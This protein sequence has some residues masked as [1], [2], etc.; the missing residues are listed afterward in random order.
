MTGKPKHEIILSAGM[1]RAGSAWFFNLTLDIWLAAGR[2]NIREY[3]ESYPLKTVLTE[4]NHNIDNFTLRKTALLMLPYLAGKSFT[5]KIHF[6]PYPLGKW[7]IRADV[8]RPTFIY[9]DPRDALLSAYEYGK[10][11]KDAG[12]PNAFSHLDSIDK[13]I[14]F[15]HGYMKDWEIWMDLA[16]PY[17]FR[18]EDLLTDYDSQVA[19]LLDFLQLGEVTAGVTEAIEKSRPKGAASKEGNHFFKG[20]IGRHKEAFT[21]E[22]LARSE[23]LFGPYLAQMGYEA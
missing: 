4:V 7:L 17:T 15:M 12:H 3:R 11:R 16:A 2:G 18:Y 9:R 21:A 6:A 22:Q 5:I 14:D 1:P 13:A 20:R 8:I 10:R 19:R 23:E